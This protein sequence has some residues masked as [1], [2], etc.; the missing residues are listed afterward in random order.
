MTVSVEPTYP[1]GRPF[2]SSCHGA[3][4]NR[5]AQLKR[6][7]ET[8]ETTT[9]A[10]LGYAFTSFP[11]SLSTYPESAPTLRTGWIQPYIMLTSCLTLDGLRSGSPRA[12]APYGFGH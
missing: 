10:I 2:G 1:Q 12:P 4:T 9:G 8:L 11:R 7:V 6:R 3:V 5:S